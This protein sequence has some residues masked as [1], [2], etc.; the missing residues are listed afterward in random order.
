MVATRKDATDR[1]RVSSKVP[2][3]E[4]RIRRCDRI[5]RLLVQIGD[6]KRDPGYEDFNDRST[7]FLVSRFLLWEPGC[8]AHA[9]HRYHPS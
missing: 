7:Q 5:S 1:S 2:R 6:A 8:G 3:R 9:K 4:R